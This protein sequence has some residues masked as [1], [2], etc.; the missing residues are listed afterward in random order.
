MQAAFAGSRKPMKTNLSPLQQAAGILVACSCLAVPNVLRAAQSLVVCSPDGTH[1]ASVGEYGRILYSDAND[2]TLKHTFYLCNAQ[3]I[4]FS[5]DGKLLAAVGGRNGSQAKI[6]VWR[7]S[8]HQQLCEIVTSG[9][10]A[11]TLAL[12]PDGIHVVT[13]EAEGRVEAWHVPDGKRRWTRTVSSALN[14]IR[15]STDGLRILVKC[16]DGIERMWDVAS[17]RN[18]FRAKEMK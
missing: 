16:V 4:I 1:T 5:D 11:R 13:A 14:S 12:S 7:L 6:K 3:A 10:Q 18:V 15:F 8:N 17:G 2:P 9:E